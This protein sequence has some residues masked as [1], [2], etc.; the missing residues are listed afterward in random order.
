MWAAQECWWARERTREVV[1]MERPGDCE[2]QGRRRAGGFEQARGKFRLRAHQGLDYR[3]TT[4]VEDESHKTTSNGRGDGGE[5]CPGTSESKVE[6][7][8]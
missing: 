4:K 1:R 2:R 3:P 7:H 5:E 8:E 6:S